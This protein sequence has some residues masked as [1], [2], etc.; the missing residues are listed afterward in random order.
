MKLSIIIPAYNEES[1]IEELIKKVKAQ[2]LKGVKKEI[3]VVDD[4]SSDKTPEILKKIKGI[5]LIK[6]E[7]NKGKGSAIRSGLEKTTGDI[8]L[9]QDA[10]LELSP[11]DYPSLIKPI[12]DGKTSI[13]YGSRLLEKKNSQHDF[14]FYAGGKF[15]T[16]AA[17]LLYNINITDEPIGYKVFK[18]PL[19]KS[20]NLKCK[21][22]EFC[23]EVTAKIAKRKIPIYEVPVRYN[24]RTTKEGKKLRFRDGI[25]AV[26][27]LLKHRFKN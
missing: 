5:K 18:T 25:Q 9:I 11:E 26:W 6:H 24:P 15:I 14:F 7:K 1:T 8:V 21:K 27:V 23:P 4:G 3:V 10:D 22:F 17:N 16:F 20:L 2:K 13:V 12:L 19:L